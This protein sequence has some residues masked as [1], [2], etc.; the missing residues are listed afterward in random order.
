MLVFIATDFRA[1]PLAAR[2]FRFAVEHEA[3][4]I[5]TKVQKAQ[6]KEAPAFGHLL[7]LLFSV[8]LLGWMVACYYLRHPLSKSRFWLLW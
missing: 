8:W 6:L 1:G 3:A 5:F 7:E 2:D 4:Y